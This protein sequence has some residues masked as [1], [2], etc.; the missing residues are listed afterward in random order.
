MIKKFAVSFMALVLSVGML[1]IC[2]SADETSVNRKATYS[3]DVVHNEEA[4][5]EAGLLELRFVPNGGTGSIVSFYG[6]S[7]DSF[8]L[9]EIDFIRTGYTFTGWNTKADGSGDSYKTGD[10]FVLNENSTLYAQWKN[11]TVVTLKVKAPSTIRKTKK[12][13]TIKVTYKENGKAVKGRYVY[14]IFNGKAYRAKTKKATVTIKIMKSA[15]KK[16]KPGSRVKYQVICLNQ[17]VNKS[18]KIKK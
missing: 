12:A 5:N 4:E 9:E 16:L 6:E 8:T 14:V 17:V 3:V 7:G 18:V 13:L 11:N 15:Y 2:S 10:T 1:P